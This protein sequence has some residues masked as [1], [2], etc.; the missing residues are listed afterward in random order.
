MDNLQYLQYNCSPSLIQALE[1]RMLADL[2]ADFGLLVKWLGCTTDKHHQQLRREKQLHWRW[3]FRRWKNNKIWS[4]W[5]CPESDP[6]IEVNEKNKLNITVKVFL[7]INFDFIT[8]IEFMSQK[9]NFTVICVSIFVSGSDSGQ[10]QCDQNL[11]FEPQKKLLVDGYNNLLILVVYTWISGAGAWYLDLDSLL[12]LFFF[13]S[14]W[15]S[16]PKRNLYFD[17]HNHIYFIFDIKIEILCPINVYVNMHITFW[18]VYTWI[19]IPGSGE[20]W[21]DIIFFLF[22]NWISDLNIF[23]FQY[24]Y[25]VLL[26]FGVFIP[27]YLKLDN[28]MRTASRQDMQVIKIEILSKINVYINMYNDILI[29][30]C[31]YLDTWIWPAS[32]DSNFIFDIRIEFLI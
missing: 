22:Q 2:H 29:L 9:K 4:H 3:A 21:C 14:E 12:M 20:P 6:D 5:G 17:M 15:N 28:W 32:R 13:T 25:L 1:L 24:T 7:L 27:G 18:E 23:I 10:P 8:R 16:W 11:I 31:L 30:G 26:W 19:W